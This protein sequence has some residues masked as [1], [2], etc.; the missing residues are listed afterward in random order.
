MTDEDRTAQKLKGYNCFIKFTD[1]EELCLYIEDLD[2]EGFES[3]WFS[4]L[5]QFINGS[6]DGITR[7]SGLAIN[8]KFIKYVK[9]I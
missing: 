8:R 6:T 4:D 1:G 2:N 9:K 7:I 3:E 5:E